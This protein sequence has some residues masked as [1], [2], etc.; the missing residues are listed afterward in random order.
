MADAVALVQFT[1]KGPGDFALE[2]ESDLDEETLAALLRSAA[3]QIEG[4]DDRA[5]GAWGRS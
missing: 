5:A 4:K 1:A 3:D 2:V